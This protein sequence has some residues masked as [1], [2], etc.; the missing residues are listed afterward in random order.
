[1]RTVLMATVSVLALAWAAA[2]PGREQPPLRA[3]TS[4]ALILVGLPGD[5]EHEAL[6]ASV[7]G[8]WRAWL[9]DALG[10]RPAD[11]RVLF[12]PSGRPGLARG[13][14]DRASIRRAVADLRRRL[15]PEDRLWVFFLGH[16]DYDGE[17][18]SF[19]L[20]GPD[21]RED[22]LGRLFAGITCREQVFWMTTSAS[23][24]FLRPLSARGR[25]VITATAADEEYN[26]TEFPQALAAVSRLPRERLDANRDG[27][28]SLLELYRRT[29]AEVEA[30]FAADRRLPTEHAQL[31]DNGDG[32]GTEEPVVDADATKKPT[33][34]GRL[35]A[36]IFLP[37]KARA[38]Q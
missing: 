3:G 37:V 28:V 31:D 36:R 10:F 29:V 26:E 14:A 2:G 25:V 21:L 27:K 33:A 32:R 15:R 13:P 22:E 11:I 30:R 34:D 7:A 8:Q 9:T 12:G 35:A 18:A 20:P 5:A 19:H 6:F 38:A 17:H 23:G 24:W 4:H 16:G 1:M